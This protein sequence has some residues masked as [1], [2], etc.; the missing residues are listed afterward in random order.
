MKDAQMSYLISRAGYQHT[1]EGVKRG[2][3]NNTIR[4]RTADYRHRYLCQKTGRKL[5][6]KSIINSGP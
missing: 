2:S 4:N 5:S 6:I 1:D 3:E